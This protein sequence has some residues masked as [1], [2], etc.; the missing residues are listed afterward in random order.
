MRL[1]RCRWLSWPRGLFHK[2]GSLLIKLRKTKFPSEICEVS[3]VHTCLYRIPVRTTFWVLIFIAL[4]SIDEKTASFALSH[5]WD[6]LSKS[7]FKA[8]TWYYCLLSIHLICL[9]FPMGL[10]W[11]FF[12]PPK[13]TIKTSSFYKWE[14][15]WCIPS[16]VS[17]TS[18]VH[19]RLLLAF[20]HFFL[21]KIQRLVLGS[22]LAWVLD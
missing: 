4:T 1:F 12:P 17:R 9:F 19:V 5:S 18:T 6:I 16:Y 8:S 7:C 20:S 3:I 10:I 13:A 22:K 21:K 15:L 2:K 11:P 14:K